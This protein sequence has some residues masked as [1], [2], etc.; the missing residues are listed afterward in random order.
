MLHL[1]L[2]KFQNKGFSLIELLVVVAIIGVLAAVAI[3]AYN[4]YRVNAVQASL[5]SSLNSIGKGFAACLTLNQ[6]AQCDTLPEIDVSCPG[7]GTPSSNTGNNRWCIT[8]SMAVGGTSYTGCLETTGGVPTVIGGWVKC[9]TLTVTYGC[10]AGAMTVSI[11]PALNCSGVGCSATAGVPTTCT[12]N[13]GTVAHSC[14]TGDA[15][16]T[17]TSSSLTCTAGQCQ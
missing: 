4:K 11:N 16:D 9:N 14:T 13:G 5:S 12:V 10:A 15:G 2:K 7:C 1:R 17:V 6:W 8:A 3:P